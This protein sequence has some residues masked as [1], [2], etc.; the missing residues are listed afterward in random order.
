MQRTR[1]RSQNAGQAAA[2]SVRRRLQ[3][4]AF[5][6]QLFLDHLTEIAKRLALFVGELARDLVHDAERSD[7]VPARPAYGVASVKPYPRLFQDDWV[8]G[9]AGVEHGVL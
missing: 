2:S 6:F 1:H 7:V 8:L 3:L 9:K 5:G 4:D